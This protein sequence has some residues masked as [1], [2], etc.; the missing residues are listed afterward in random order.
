MLDKLQRTEVRFG[1][2]IYMQVAKAERAVRVA[3]LVRKMDVLLSTGLPVRVTMAN[4]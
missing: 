1:S 3:V 4:E 2:R